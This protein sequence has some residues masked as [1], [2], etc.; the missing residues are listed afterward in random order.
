MPPIGWFL[1]FITIVAVFLGVRYL[2][3]YIHKLRMNSRKVKLKD[4][5]IETLEAQ[6]RNEELRSVLDEEEKLRLR[7]E[8]AKKKRA[9]S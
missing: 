8:A 3:E 6:K 7:A 9:E 4:I 5:E 1:L 2:P